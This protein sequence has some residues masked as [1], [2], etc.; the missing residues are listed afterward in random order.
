MKINIFNT[1]EEMG[2]AAA[3]LGAGLINEAISTKGKANIIVATGASQFEMLNFLIK[4]KLP[5]K[6]YNILRVVFL[7]S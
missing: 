5:F 1:K 7:N 6:A 2:E 4:Q 3:L